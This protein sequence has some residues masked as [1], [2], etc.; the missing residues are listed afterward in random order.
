MRQPRTCGRC[1]LRPIAYHGR[2]HCYECV[3]RARNSVLLCKVCGSDRDYY[4]AGRC[5]RCYRHSPDIAS[6]RDCLGWGVTR[7]GK[8]LCEGCQGWRRRFPDPATCPS[9]QRHLS[10]NAR[11]YCRLCTRQAGLVRLPHQSID[12]VEANRD[13]QQL[14]LA[15]MFRQKRPD[16]PTTAEPTGAWPRH[17][18]VQHEQLTLLPGNGRDLAAARLRGFPGPP[19]L[20]DLAA[21]LN[22]AVHEHAR[23]HG[24]RGATRDGVLYALLILQALQDTPGARIRHSEATVLSQL[25]GTPL[26]ATSEVLTAV[27]MFTEDRDAPLEAWFSRHTEQV[28]E[29]M[30]AELRSWFLALRDGSSIAPRSHP[31]SRETVRAQIFNVTPTL[32][33]WHGDGHR[34]LREITREDI[35]RVLPSDAQQRY[36]AISSLRGL[37][38]FLKTR[39][40]VFMNPTARMSPG[41]I[42]TN[43]PL[44]LDLTI[45]REAI[46]STNPARAALSSLIAFHGPRLMH[47]RALQ[48]TDINDGRMTVP[49]QTIP[50]APPV[51]QALRG[52]L[53]ERARRWPH[54][55]NPHVFITH[56]SALRTT[57]ASMVWIRDTLGMPGKDI[58]NDRILHEA[59]ATRGDIRRL[60]DLFGISVHTALRYTHS[61]EQPNTPGPTTGS[62]TLQLRSK[63][64][65]KS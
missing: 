57:P 63:K 35:S 47:I 48:L 45:L 41:Q 28:G 37:F 19:P 52:W 22:Q 3:P 46:N 5:R 4:T 39:G 7:R 20:P 56:H 61:P 8:W 62:G 16:P 65:Q 33:A 26:N 44:P 58:R 64:L 50:L 23:Q 30:L 24:W 15:G 18:P 54:T 36:K 6:C 42:K 11:G 34:S 25:R 49:G 43:Q 31:R 51:R 1:G 2:K 40:V 29:Q 9:C 13:G 38:R 10:L 14:F 17:Y 55:L 59:I 60:A 21:A 32:L 12:V 53:D 27:G